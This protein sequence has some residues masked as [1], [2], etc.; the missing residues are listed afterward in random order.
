MTGIGKASQTTG[1]IDAKANR[2]CPQRGS[3]G[4]QALVSGRNQTFGTAL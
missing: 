4:L 2:L 1:V 3:F